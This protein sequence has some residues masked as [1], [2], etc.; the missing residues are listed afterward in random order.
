MQSALSN[1]NW[2]QIYAHIYAWTMCAR[3]LIKLKELHSQRKVFKNKI[4]YTAHTYLIYCMC[5]I[6]CLKTL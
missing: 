1:L 4:K 5:L 2:P 6:N 3:V